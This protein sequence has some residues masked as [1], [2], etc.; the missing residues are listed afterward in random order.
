MKKILCYIL[1]IT[2]I[3]TFTGCWGIRDISNKAFITAIGIDSV[4]ADTKLPDNKPHIILDGGSPVDS[5]GSTFPVST[6]GAQEKGDNDNIPPQLRVS[7]EIVKPALLRS[8][9]REKSAAL[10]STVSGESIQDALQKLQTRI[11]REISL[12]HLR[13]LIIGEQMAKQNF[14]NTFSYFEKHPEIARRLRLNFVQ[15][16]TAL[17]ILKTQPLFEKYVADELVHFSQLDDK[18]SLGRINPFAFF[19]NDMMT[20]NGRGLAARV[21]TADNGQI[22]DRSGSAVFHKWKLAGW[23]SEKETQEV[24]WLV[25]HADSAVVANT[26][27]GIYTYWVDNFR[28]SI[29]PVIEQK[30]LKKFKVSVKTGGIILQEQG[31]FVHLDD[32]EALKSMEKVFAQTISEEIKSALH[33][34][35]KDIKVDYLGFGT[36]LRAQDPDLYNKIDWDKTFQDIPV[37]VSVDSDISMLA[38]S[39]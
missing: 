28:T 6:K 33:K 13:V 15:N 31:K 20:T 36:K 23:L 26:G 19:L 12:S 39:K 2:F 11:S 1:L 9:T 16:G 30:K 14:K 18:L 25:G 3:L 38:L 29:K 21:T 4:N 34:A 5:K 17:D 10:V 32:T 22:I 37:E 24:N 27:K 35:Q 7:V 8:N